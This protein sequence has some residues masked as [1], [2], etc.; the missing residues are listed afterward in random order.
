M[1]NVS[2]NH[3]NASQNMCERRTD[4]YVF[5]K[6]WKVWSPPTL[7]LCKL[8]TNNVSHKQLHQLQYWNTTYNTDVENEYF[9]F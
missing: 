4:Q 9:Y 8:F 2:I 7:Q 5:Y 6:V 3:A 1:W